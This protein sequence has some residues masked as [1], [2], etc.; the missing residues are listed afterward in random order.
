MCD[1]INTFNTCT[2]ENIIY[3]IEDGTL[4]IDIIE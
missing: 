1:C 3:K 2:L 4:D